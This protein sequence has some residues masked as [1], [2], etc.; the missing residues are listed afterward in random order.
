MLEALMFWA[1]SIPVSLV[2]QCGAL[3]KTIDIAAKNGYVINKTNHNEDMYVDLMRVIVENT[4][5]FDLYTIT[6]LLNLATS[7]NFSYLIVKYQNAICDDMEYLGYYR[8]MTEEEQEIYNNK[9]STF[10]ALKLAFE[11]RKEEYKEIPVE[12]SLTVINESEEL[13]R[14]KDLKE[15]YISLRQNI[16][17]DFNEVID[18]QKEYT[19]K[20]K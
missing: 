8:K 19:R 10:T 5:R 4:P 17:N 1:L 9:P 15:K 16:D 12:K 11:E 7:F 2:M 20:L 13:K 14:I 18:E 6:P 3:Y